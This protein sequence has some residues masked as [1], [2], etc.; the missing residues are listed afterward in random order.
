M[1]VHFEFDMSDEDAANLVGLLLEAKTN[2]QVKGY[3][4]EP[5]PLRDW[6]EKHAKYLEKLTG[7]VVAG[8]SRK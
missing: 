7:T 2:T 8:S 4:A 3:R 1:T 6:L 5:G